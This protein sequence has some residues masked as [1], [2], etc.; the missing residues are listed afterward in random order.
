MKGDESAA[1]DNEL[2]LRVRDGDDVAAFR[3]LYA[4]YHKRI[5][6]YCAH[7]VKDEEKARDA[8]QNVF[9]A[10]YEQRRQFEPGEFSKWLFTIAKR[11]SM[12]VYQRYVTDTVGADVDD[13]M[14]DA[15]HQDSSEME[16][17][18]VMR[19]ALHKAI[20]GLS[21]DFKTVIRMRYFDD[22]PYQE[23]A[24]V[25]NIT[26]SL[27]KVRVNRAKAALQKAM[28]MKPDDVS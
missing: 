28:N 11:Q 4:R 22:L 24:D 26:L 7:I 21:E 27:A 8:F 16:A 14:M 1:S 12:R 15:L 3:E 25:L 9:T 2:F 20:D 23:I 18:V 19:D 17:D 6:A 5:F 13:D 10:V